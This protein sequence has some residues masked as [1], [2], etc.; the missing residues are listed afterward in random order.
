MSVL[1]SRRK[2]VLR[3]ATM[4]CVSVIAGTSLT[5][6][7]NSASLPPSPTVK[8]SSPASAGHAQNFASA[9]S[10]QNTTSQASDSNIVRIAQNKVRPVGHI[11]PWKPKVNEREWKHIVLHHTASSSGS[12]QSIHE[13]HKRRKDRNGNPWMGIGYHFVIGNG[14]GMKDGE[15]QPTFRWKK[16]LH[17]AHAGV[18]EYNELGIGIA[19]VGNFEETRPTA[20]Q[21]KSAKRL[22]QSLRTSYSISTKRVVTHQKVNKTACPGRFFSLERITRVDGETTLNTV[23]LASSDTFPLTAERREVR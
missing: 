9:S 23:G 10:N 2:H 18:K 12:V 20:A 7:M 16:Q 13:I 14:K 4:V 17:G 3:A 15:I 22:V 19:L 5:G 6:C 21:L 8:S 1:K 11:N